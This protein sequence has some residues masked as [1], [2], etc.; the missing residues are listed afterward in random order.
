[1]DEAFEAV[2]KIASKLSELI[3][4]T[5]VKMI[6]NTKN[7]RDIDL[8]FL[9]KDPTPEVRALTQSESIPRELRKHVVE[10]KW[11][12]RQESNYFFFLF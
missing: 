9:V 5:D 8:Q 6:L 10:K 4:T 11:L 12:G 7:A 3:G 2:D 1:M